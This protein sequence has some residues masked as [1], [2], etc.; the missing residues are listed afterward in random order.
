VENGDRT[1][2]Q[3]RPEAA[4]P[5]DANTLSDELVELFAQRYDNQIAANQFL[6]EAG[7]R[8]ERLP[9][10][11]GLTPLQV[12]CEVNLRLGYG[13]EPDGAGRLVRAALLEWPDNQQLRAEARRLLGDRE[14]EPQASWTNGP[15]SNAAPRFRKR[16]WDL[17]LVEASLVV[18]A[19]S[20][21]IFASEVGRFG[22]PALIAGS[23]AVVAWQVFRP[24]RVVEAGWAA[25]AALA[26]ASWGVVV[27]RATCRGPVAAVLAESGLALVFA[28]SYLFLV[29]RARTD[30]PVRRRTDGPAG[31]GPHAIPRQRRSRRRPLRSVSAP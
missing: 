9:S 14:I 20:V 19:G 24:I 8:P 15:T 31:P 30:V 10:W 12:W 29:A 21:R 13:A 27:A 26:G 1:D 18:A 2:D 5:P 3:N 22:T 6:R 23:V 28:L 16:V 4:R 7:L 25:G 11:T 17:V